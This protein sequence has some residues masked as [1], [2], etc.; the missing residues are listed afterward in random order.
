MLRIRWRCADSLLSGLLGS[1]G[2]CGPRVVLPAHLSVQCRP[3]VRSLLQGCFRIGLLHCAVAQSVAPT[4]AHDPYIL[5]PGQAE[6]VD[7]PGNSLYA[8]PQVVL[9]DTVSISKCRR[10]LGKKGEKQD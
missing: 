1:S 6:P 2:A 7:H 4:T 5:R 8:S 3:A 10:R 9:L